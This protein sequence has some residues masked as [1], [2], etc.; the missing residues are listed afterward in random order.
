MIILGTWMALLAT[1]QA[2]QFGIL[3]ALDRP[4]MSPVTLITEIIA[5]AIYFILGEL[6]DGAI[7]HIFVVGIISIDMI[8]KWKT[9]KTL[10]DLPIPH[11]TVIRGWKEQSIDSADLIPCNLMMVWEGVKIPADGAVLLWA[12]L[13]VDESALTGEAAGVQQSMMRE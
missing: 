11:I 3:I 2:L 5:A 9:D 6:R 10:K 13:C 8:Q 12:D 1:I 4:L 7:M